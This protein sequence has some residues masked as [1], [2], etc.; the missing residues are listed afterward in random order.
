LKIKVPYLE[1]SNFEN[2]RFPSSLGVTNFEN[3]RFLP[4]VSNF[5][6]EK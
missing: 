1:A 4:G 5:E 6:N 2:K 3:K